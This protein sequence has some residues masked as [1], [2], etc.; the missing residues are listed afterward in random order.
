MADPIG[1]ALKAA[2]E[3][4]FTRPMPKSPAAQLRF[5]DRG[6]K[7]STKALAQILG[8]SPRQALRYKKGEARLPEAKLRKATR[9]RWQ[10]R[11][12][13]RARRQM[14]DNGVTITIT[15]R[16][17]YT[18]EPG[19]TDDARTR[20]LIQP[21]PPEYGRRLLDAPTEADRRQIIAEG[22]GH[23]YFRDGGTRAPG[24]E[25][26]VT[27]IDHIDIEPHP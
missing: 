18:A 20:S 12:R 3:G 19:T 2:E 17:G 21:L 25:V 14:R 22:L 6:V 13:A 8:V 4:A 27:D 9:E 5:L 15:A 16:L 23:Y 26:E 1:R 7:G 11:V 24:L 10:P